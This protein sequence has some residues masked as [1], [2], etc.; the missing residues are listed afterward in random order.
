M[1]LSDSVLEILD[2]YKYS[3]LPLEETMQKLTDSLGFYTTVSSKR[4]D[5]A[6][7]LCD[8]KWNRI[9]KQELSEKVKELNCFQ[10]IAMW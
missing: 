1:R 3:N 2:K 4:E 8:Y 10:E 9:T 7:L 5:F 6:C